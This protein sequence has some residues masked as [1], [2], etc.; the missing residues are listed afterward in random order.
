MFRSG[1]MTFSFNFSARLTFFSSSQDRS[2]KGTSPLSAGNCFSGSSIYIKKGK[3]TG[4]SK[5]QTCCCRP[6]ARSSWPTLG[7]QPN[8]QTL[9]PKE[10]H[11]SVPLSGWLQRLYSKL[12][13]ILRQIS[14]LLELPPWSS[15]T[16]SLLMQQHTL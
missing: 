7:L 1:M 5:L 2:T 3:Y 9:N 13:M 4:I 8:S 11:S 12:G 16:E 14:G 10:T 15:S 6:Q